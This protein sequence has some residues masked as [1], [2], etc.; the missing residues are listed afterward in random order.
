MIFSTSSPCWSWPTSQWRA[1]FVEGH[2]LVI[3]GG[4]AVFFNPEPLSEFFDLFVLGEA[5]EVIREF[6]EVYRNALSEK[7]KEEKDDLLRKL[8]GIEGIYVPKFYQVTYR[9][10]WK[11]R[12]DGARTRDSS[13]GQD[14][15]GFKRLD[16]F[17]TQSTLFTPDTEFKEM[18][19][20][21]VNRGCPR[22]CRFCAAC[23]V[24]HPFRNRSL[25]SS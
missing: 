9:R 14:G 11:D 18:A 23:F 17:P 12:I 7:R 21:E 2:P 16:R 24:Y 20:V 25:S 5:E 1:A 19:L 3:A 6:L 13:T 4:V 8:A 15:D 22:G 10:G